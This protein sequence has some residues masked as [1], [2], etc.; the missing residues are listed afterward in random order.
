MN[1]STCEIHDSCI[2]PGANT[3]KLFELKKKE[4]TDKRRRRCSTTG[5]VPNTRC[6]GSC[7]AKRGTNVQR[8]VNKIACATLQ[9]GSQNVASSFE[10][11]GTRSLLCLASAVVCCFERAA[12]CAT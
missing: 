12:R 8:Q 2:P 6:F 11:S 9:G 5:P 10:P 1:T 7:A 3:K 4:N